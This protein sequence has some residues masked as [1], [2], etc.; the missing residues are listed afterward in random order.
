MAILLDADGVIG[1]VP[2]DHVADALAQ[3]WTQAPPQQADAFLGR[4]ARAEKFGPHS[5]N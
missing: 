2:D 3:G 5:V 4:R 1:E